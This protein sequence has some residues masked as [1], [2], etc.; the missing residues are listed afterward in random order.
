MAIADTVW[1]RLARFNPPRRESDRRRLDRSFPMARLIRVLRVLVILAVLGLLGWA[2][3][4]EMRNSHLEAML[5][6]RFDRGMSFGVGRGA[7]EAIRFPKGGPYDERLGYV[8]LPQFVA[9]LDEHRFQVTDQARWSQGLLR[10][11]GLGGFPIYPE[12]DQAGIRI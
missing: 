5:F 10:F 12:K 7:S 6:D 11:V 1:G 9:S 4:W 8:Q 2:A 3:A